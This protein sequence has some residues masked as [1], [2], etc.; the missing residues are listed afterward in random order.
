VPAAAKLLDRARLGEFTLHMPNVC[1]AE[2]R[3]AIVT[4]CQPRK[5]A[6]A[7]RGF[8]SWSEPAGKVTK[9]DAAA[10][11]IV[12]N[13]FE[14]SVEDDLSRLDVTLK[15]LAGLPFLKIFGLDEDMLHRATDLALDGIYLKPFDQSILAAVLVRSSRLWDA[16]ERAISFCEIDGDLQPWDRYGNAKPPLTAAYD[17]A[18]VWVYGDFM[19]EQ[20]A[21]SDDFE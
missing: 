15:E 18:H 4:R 17:K 13:Q 14:S 5:E 1:L 10:A 11:R 3:Q 8:L 7:I 20:P 21:R 6:A 16:G 12:I 2:A 19:L 9:A